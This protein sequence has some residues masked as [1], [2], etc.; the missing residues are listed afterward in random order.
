MGDSKIQKLFLVGIVLL[1]GAKLE[2]GLF[3]SELHK[4][5]KPKT[6]QEEAQLIGIWKGDSI[7]QV[8]SSPCH[9]EKAIYEISKAKATGKLTIDLGKIVDG[10]PESMTVIDFTYDPIKHTLTCEQKYGIWEL[11][12]KGDKMEGTLT[13]PDQV[14]Y[15]RMT[16][17]KA[18]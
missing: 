18:Q 13:T 6:A 15:R 4:T 10:K 5:N 1:L 8:K 7:C 12:I 17:K 3:A 11:I 9:D 16:L 14:I 2:T